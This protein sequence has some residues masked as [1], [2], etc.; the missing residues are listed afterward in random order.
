MAVKNYNFC[1]KASRMSLPVLCKSSE[2]DGRNAGKNDKMAAVFDPRAFSVSGDES[3]FLQFSGFS[4]K[5]KKWRSCGTLCVVYFKLDGIMLG[6][7][8]ECFLTD[9][10]LLLFVT[11]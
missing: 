11:Y 10:L 3:T 8:A 1:I 4:G 2:T 9:C 6:E 5:V 7:I